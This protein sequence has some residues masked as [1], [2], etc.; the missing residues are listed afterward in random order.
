MLAL[1]H[2]D[3]SDNATQ[4]V[5]DHLEVVVDRHGALND[6]GTRKLGVGHP[7]PQSHDQGH[8]CSRPHQD[9]ATDAEPAVRRLCL[10][11]IRGHDRLAFTA[12]GVG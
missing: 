6:H 11:R 2:L 3:G 8:S 12:E 4:L 5:L 9:T 10:F 7:A 1:F